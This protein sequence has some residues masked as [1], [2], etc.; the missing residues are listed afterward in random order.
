M[1]TTRITDIGGRA[2]IIEFERKRVKNMNARVR[3]DGTLYVSLPYWVSFAEAEKFI[4]SKASF[5]IKALDEVE[6][7]SADEEDWKNYGVL[8]HALKSTSRMI[9][10]ADLADAAAGLE[11]AANAENADKI[12][13]GH[14]WLMERYAAVCGAISEFLPP[15]ETSTDAVDEVMEFAPGGDVME[16]AP[17]EDVLEFAPDDEVLE[18]SPQ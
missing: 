11:A 15:S 4:Q 14:D 3:R 1:S 17:D 8:T 12:R 18:F 2:V 10:V 13:E 9:G 5:F 6:K 16:F 7:R